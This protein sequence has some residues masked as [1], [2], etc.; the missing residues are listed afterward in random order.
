MFNFRWVAI[1]RSSRLLVLAAFGAALAIMTFAATSVVAASS[2]VECGQLTAYTAPDPAG[3]TD[4]NVQLG[5]SAPWD[6]LATATISAAAESALPTLVNNA[7]TCLALDFD[8]S[9]KVSAIDFA[10]SGTIT[11]SVD[12]DSGSGF[13]LF[14]NR[15]IVPDFVT[16]TYPGLAALFVTSYQAGTQLTVTFTV[17]PLNGAFTGFDG[18]AAFCGHGKM[19]VD[20]D[21]QVGAAVIPAAVLDAGDIKSLRGAGARQTC[22]SVQS[23]GTI[24][25]GTGAISTTTDVAIVVAPAGATVTPPPTSTQEAAATSAEGPSVIGWLAGVFLV[26]AVLIAVQSRRPGVD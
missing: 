11:G 16:N 12:F 9:G 1:L 15:L 6:V 23:S 13:Y 21:G 2:S 4:G 22:A 7:P 24:D 18:A 10:A 14:A 20:G 3:P 17:D 25:S 19:R 5:L 8:N 26:S